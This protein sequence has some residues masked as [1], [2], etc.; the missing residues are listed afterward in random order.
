MKMRRASF[1]EGVDTLVGSNSVFKGSIESDGTVRVDGK[2]IGDIKVTGD[3]YVGKGA[4]VEGNVDAG[5]V[6][7]AG[8][9]KGNIVAKGLLKILSTARLYGDIKINS[10]V[11]DEGALFQGKCEMLEEQEEEK[12][13]IKHKRNYKKSTVLEDIYEENN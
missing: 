10:F 3:V 7:L 5:N 11:A 2:V 13:S 12:S 1:R 4:T 9:V 6:H 8:M